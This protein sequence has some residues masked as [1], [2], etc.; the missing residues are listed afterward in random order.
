MDIKDEMMKRLEDAFSPQTLDIIDE[1]ENHRG[2]SGYREGGQSHFH[3]K[4][5]A[6]IFA[7]MGRVAR[8]RAIHK[9]LGKDII[10]RIHA[11]SM[12]IEG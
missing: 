11:L 3:I 9:A 4:I 10:D 5:S 2:H 1:S 8:E 7:E 6:T 12:K